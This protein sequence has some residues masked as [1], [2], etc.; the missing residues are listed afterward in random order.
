MSNQ[1]DVECMS[2]AL[3][4]AKRGIYTTR[5]NP[6]VGCVITNAH[7]NI[8]G[9]GY[10]RRAGG[11]HAE[12]IALEQAGE[13]A[14]HGTAYVTLEPCCHQGKTGP[15]TQA[16]L[17]A[18][19][20][21]VVIAMRDPKPLVAGKGIGSLKQHG[22]DV[23]ENLLCEQARMVNR[24]FIKRMTTGMPWVTLKVASS[25]D[26]RTALNN[27]KSKWITSEQARLDVQKIRARQ[28][29][30][31]S[32]IG[33]VLADDPSLNVRID[34]A[35]LN[36]DE[37]LIQPIRIVADPELKMP[38]DAKMLGLPGTTLIFTDDRLSTDKFAEIESCEVIG[39]HSDQGKLDMKSILKQLAALEI[40]SVLVESGAT[41]LGAL[42]NAKLAD[43]LIYYSAPILMGS[44]SRGMFDTNEI[45]NMDEC[46]TLEHQDI[47]QIGN[48]IRITSLIHY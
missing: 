19:I 1:R 25:L 30:I 41:L 27:G 37:A 2:H 46:I 39:V 13:H 44:H 16:L 45:T 26:G 33:T 36:I 35:E 42:I 11:P 5:P 21:K 4:L 8:V 34:S 43:E 28:D 47:R 20:K 15:C 14:K 22:I 32:G 7:G 31:M 3:R 6:N 40:N 23:V 12:I 18:G 48:D 38:T 17:K 29:A 9:E 24:G 10:H